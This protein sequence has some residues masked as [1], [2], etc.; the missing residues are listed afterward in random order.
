[1]TSQVI[2]GDTDSVMVR[3]GVKTVE[4]SMKLGRKAAEMISSHF[5]PPIK[6]EFE[7]V[8]LSLSLFR[9]TEL[10]LSLSCRFIIHTFSST[11][12]G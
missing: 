12:R 11:R 6:L 8:C 4:D 1:M 9:V 2:Y 3:F 5:P 10:S 7:K